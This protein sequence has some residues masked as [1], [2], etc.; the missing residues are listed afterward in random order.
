MISMKFAH[1][2]VDISESTRG[3]PSSTIAALALIGGRKA[4]P[5]ARPLTVSL[6]LT[7][8]AP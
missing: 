4:S 2:E 5:A 3:L 8:T 7:M 1:S 6:D